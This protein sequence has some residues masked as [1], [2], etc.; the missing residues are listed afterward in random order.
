MVSRGLA[1]DQGGG[2]ASAGVSPLVAGGSD[3]LGLSSAPV[4]RCR[5]RR[6][7]VSRLVY[8]LRASRGRQRP[9][10]ATPA[11]KP[12]PP[13]ADAPGS[14]PAHEPR[15]RSRSH[16]VGEGQSTSPP[17]WQTVAASGSSG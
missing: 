3:G 11:N 2:G 10:S 12:R 8:R 4:N 13:V 7:A 17:G 6:R 16:P 14:P 5:S 9:E 1:K 15:D